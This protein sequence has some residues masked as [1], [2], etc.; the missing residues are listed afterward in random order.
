MGFRKDVID[1][2]YRRRQLENQQALA[3]QNQR[4]IQQ[5]QALLEE[6]KLT[7]EE[8]KERNLQRKIKE[9]RENKIRNSLCLNCEYLFKGDIELES[10]YCPNCG[11][12]LEKTQYNHNIQSKI[13]L[14]RTKMIRLSRE[15][16]KLS[17]LKKSDR[18]KRKELQTEIN[19][20]LDEIGSLSSKKFSGYNIY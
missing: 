13:E 11:Q 3:L 17:K 20:L 19:K 1:A 9:E 8:K 7:D 18:I 2:Q 15:M 10:I 16:N 5:Q 12:L 4:L 6:A 14:R